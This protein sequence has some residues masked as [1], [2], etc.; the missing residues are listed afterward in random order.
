MTP[1]GRPVT[2]ARVLRVPRDIP[3][4]S[5]NDLAS[6][7]VGRSVSVRALQRVLCTCPAPPCAYLGG[8]S[9]VLLPFQVVLEKDG[10]MLPLGTD[11]RPN[12]QPTLAPHTHPTHT[13]RPTPFLPLSSK[14]LLLPTVPVTPP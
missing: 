1:I 9:A 6:A 8:D 13:H 5:L 2:D 4:A 14:A 10:V 7:T 3:L 12:S 11:V